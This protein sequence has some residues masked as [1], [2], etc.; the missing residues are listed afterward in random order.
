MDQLPHRLSV[1]RDNT[2]KV[3]TIP[4]HVRLYTLHRCSQ[5]ALGHHELSESKVRATARV[6]DVPTRRSCKLPDVCK[7]VPFTNTAPFSIRAEKDPN[8]NVDV[9]TVEWWIYIRSQYHPSH[10]GT[11]RGGV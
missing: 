3:I 8:V 4:C 1:L 2:S 5:W 9:I 10:S 7:F 11:T 6:I